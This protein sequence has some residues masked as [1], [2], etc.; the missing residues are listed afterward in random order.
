MSDR[1]AK[2]LV[3]CGRYDHPLFAFDARAVNGG[4]VELLIRFKHAAPELHAYSCILRARE[5]DHPQFENDCLPGRGHRHRRLS[6]ARV[7]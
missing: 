6:H 5:L 2:V 4:D 1:L 7:R 3:E